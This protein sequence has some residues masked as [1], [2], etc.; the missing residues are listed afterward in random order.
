MF[1]RFQSNRSLS[2]I[3]SKNNHRPSA[4]L[5]RSFSTSNVDKIYLVF[6]EYVEQM[7][8]KR[9]PVREAHLAMA[10]SFKEKGIFV[11]GGAYGDISGG[12]LIFKAA[13]EGVVKNFVEQDPYYTNGLITKWSMKEWTPVIGLES[14]LPKK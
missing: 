14:I 7:E 5:P 10:R 4:S 12:A 1:S 11:A 3:N 2:S 9:K 6:Y 13:N 8:I